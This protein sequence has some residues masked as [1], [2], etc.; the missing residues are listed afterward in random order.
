MQS[1]KMFGHNPYAKLGLTHT[2]TPDVVAV[3][4]SHIALL[5]SP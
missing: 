2:H 4:A 1:V 3:K 5:T